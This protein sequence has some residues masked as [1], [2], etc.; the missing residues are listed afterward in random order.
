MN[1]AHILFSFSGRINRAKWWLSILVVVGFEVFYA[2]L[3][4]VLA[5]DAINALVGLLLFVLIIWVTLAAGAKRLHDLDRTGAWLILFMGAPIVLSIVLAMQ[6]GFAVFAALA[7][8]EVPEATDFTNLGTS[9]MIIG[10]LGL[11]IGIWSL[12]W[13][14]CLPGTLGPNRYGPDPL[15][16]SRQPVAYGSR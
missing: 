13:F 14:G 10:L 12:V 1:F 5:S 9:V 2:A 6:I 4:R 15:E 8:G 7:T 16:A 11:A 3:S